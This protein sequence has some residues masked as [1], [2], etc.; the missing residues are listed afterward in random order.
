VDLLLRVSHF[1]CQSPLLVV[2]RLGVDRGFLVWV[3]GSTCSGSTPC[4]ACQC[5]SWHITR[6]AISERWSTQP[7]Q[8]LLPVLVTGFSSTFNVQR[9]TLYE[10]CFRRSSSRFFCPCHWYPSTFCL[11]NASLLCILWRFLSET[12]WFECTHQGEASNKNFS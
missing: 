9:P 12:S 4:G 5:G 2:R 11:P 7:Y 6:Y 3:T 1:Q 10:L 8:V